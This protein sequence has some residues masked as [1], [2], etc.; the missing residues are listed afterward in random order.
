MRG[1]RGRRGGKSQEVY[2]ITG[3]PVSLSDDVRGRQRR[4]VISMLIRTVAVV[5]T[6]VLWNVSTPL[7]VATLV[8]GAVLPYVAVVMANAGR[9]NASS[10]PRTGAAGPA[11]PAEHPPALPPAAGRGPEQDGDRGSDRGEDRGGRGTPG[12]PG[13]PGENNSPGTQGS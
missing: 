12:S 5:L 2:R 7:A 8:L 1:R 13:A 9:E 3:A 4:Y 10:L 11:E 6:L